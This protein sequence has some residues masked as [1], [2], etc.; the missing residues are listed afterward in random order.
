MCAESVFV[1]VSMC[2]CMRFYIL[3]CTFPGTCA[4]KSFQHSCNKTAT[5]LV[6][7]I[8]KSPRMRPIYPIS[9]VR[10]WMDGGIDGWMGWGSKV[11]MTENCAIASTIR[12]NYKVIVFHLYG[13]IENSRAYRY[14]KKC[15]TSPQVLRLLN[16][17]FLE[18]SLYEY[19]FLCVSWL[20]AS[21]MCVSWL[22]ILW[23]RLL[24]LCLMWLRVF[25][26]RVTGL[27]IV[28][29]VWCLCVL[30]LCI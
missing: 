21:W 9:S 4:K 13:Y 27:C 28:L 25:W 18:A 6:Y 14:I 3:F 11:E 15:P 5:H 29:C 26:L 20:C 12:D 2:V 8:T 23:L 1:C 22:C 19:A 10:S 16:F 7:W 17:M 24:R 30:S